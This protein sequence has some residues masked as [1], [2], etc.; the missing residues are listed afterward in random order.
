MRQIAEHAAPEPPGPEP[1]ARAG[2]RRRHGCAVCRRSRAPVR[3]SRLRGQHSR[4]GRRVGC[5]RAVRALVQQRAPWQRAE[6]P[7]LDRRVRRRARRRGR[8]RR[9]AAT[10]TRSCSS[11]TRQKPSTS[12]RPRCARALAC[13]RARSSITPTCFPGG[14]TI[15][16]CSGSPARQTSC[17]DACEHALRSRA[18]A[19]RPGR[20]HRRLERRR[21]GVAGRRARRSCPPLMARSSS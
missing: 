11:A 13:F 6:I 1:A 20:R 19:D 12:S 17:C 8:F 2:D 14:A 21:G 4:D 7:R 5:R 16:G 18:A 3:E 15:S 10:T 9:R